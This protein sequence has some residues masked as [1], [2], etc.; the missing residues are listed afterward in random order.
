M[1]DTLR[2]LWMR[3]ALL[4]YCFCLLFLLS[5]CSSPTPTR[6]PHIDLFPPLGTTL[7]TYHGHFNA[8]SGVAWSPDGKHIASASYDKTVQI[9]DAMKGK[10]LVTYHGHSNWVTAVAWSLDG[11]NIATTCY[12]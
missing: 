9:W 4:I 6:S 1:T 11:I 2:P 7:Y 12:D 3:R 8:V 10:H 5:A